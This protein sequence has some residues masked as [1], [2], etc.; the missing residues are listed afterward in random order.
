MA[1]QVLRTRP[2]VERGSGR[3]DWWHR[4]REARAVLNAPA[5]DGQLGTEQPPRDVGIPQEFSCSEVEHDHSRSVDEAFERTSVQR[6]KIEE[7]MVLTK[8]TQSIPVLAAGASKKNAKASRNPKVAKSRLF[9]WERRNCR[10]H[11]K[12]LETI[13]EGLHSKD[14]LADS[15]LL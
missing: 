6:R 11:S 14:S 1:L 10:N 7:L 3:R 2:G 8:E 9:A 12:S 15:Q 4:A 13:P 5:R